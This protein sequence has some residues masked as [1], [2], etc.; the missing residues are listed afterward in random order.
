MVIDHPLGR[1]IDFLSMA[2]DNRNARHSADDQWSSL[3]KRGFAARFGGIY[4]KGNGRD[5]PAGEVPEGQR[6]A[7]CG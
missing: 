3:R 6:G 7:V 4:W 5:L 1:S 2:F